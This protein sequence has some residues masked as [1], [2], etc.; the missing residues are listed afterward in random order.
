MLPRVGFAR[1]LQ[2][3]ARGVDAAFGVV[4]GA[5]GQVVNKLLAIGQGVFRGGIVADPVA[6][7]EDT[8][9]SAM[10]RRVPFSGWLLIFQF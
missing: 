4:E 2:A 6:V 10:I 1:L 7:I 3:F 9:L 8:L 5:P